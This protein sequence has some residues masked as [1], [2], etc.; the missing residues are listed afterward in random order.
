[1]TD[2]LDTP[3]RDL[4]CANT[5][6]GLQE[7]RSFEFFRLETVPGI[8]G[9]FG[10]ATW[11]LVLQACDQEPVVRQAAIA[12]GAL[13]EKMSLQSSCDDGSTQIETEFP[14]MQHGKAMA[15][16]R[17]YLAN[18]KTPR[19]DVILMSALIFISIEVM[20]VNYL[21]ASVHLEKSLPLLQPKFPNHT[22]DIDPDLSLAFR[23]L[24]LHASK[25]STVHSFPHYGQI[26]ELHSL[27]ILI[28]CVLRARA[29]DTR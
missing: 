17:K 22:P 29:H 19:I 7:H 26:P 18:E 21:N 13:H 20:Q 2:V 23:Q 8:G 5:S 11:K 25:V 6:D 10:I 15:T 4:R 12:L 28:K 1:V 16:V 27:F 9:F 24:D 14:L 3:A